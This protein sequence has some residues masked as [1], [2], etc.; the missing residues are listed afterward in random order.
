MHRFLNVGHRENYT[1][2]FIDGTRKRDILA[3]RMYQDV[4]V[5]GCHPNVPDKDRHSEADKKIP[6][7]IRSRGN[8]LR[9]AC[10]SQGTA[11]FEVGPQVKI[12]TNNP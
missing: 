4:S 5:I 7:R 12:L 3:K 10:H 1:Q 9:P 11:T 8:G 2:S 6:P